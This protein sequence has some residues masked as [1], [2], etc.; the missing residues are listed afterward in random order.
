[1]SIEDCGKYR[2][3]RNLIL[4]TFAWIIFVWWRCSHS[5]T[6]CLQKRRISLQKKMEK[7]IPCMTLKFN[8][9]HTLSISCHSIAALSNET[10]TKKSRRLTTGNN[11]IRNDE[12]WQSPELMT[13]E[14]FKLIFWR[15]L[16]S[17][18]FSPRKQNTWNWREFEP[19]AEEFCLRGNSVRKF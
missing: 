12:V 13:C 18:C 6:L 16:K 4:R 14:E 1:M 3:L 15:G 7:A 9:K 2:R 19:R 5:S 10:N 17:M 11:G 8:N